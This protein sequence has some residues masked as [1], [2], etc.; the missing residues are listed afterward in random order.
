[1]VKEF[2]AP[3]HEQGNMFKVHCSTDCNNELMGTTQMSLNEGIYKMKQYPEVK[4]NGLNPYVLT[5]Q[6]LKNNVG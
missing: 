1:M 6:E 5:Q 2:C 3:E 4:I